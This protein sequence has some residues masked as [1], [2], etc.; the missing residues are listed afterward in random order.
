MDRRTGLG[1]RRYALPA[2]ALYKIIDMRKTILT[3]F[4]FLVVN[5]LLIWIHIT[6]FQSTF[7]WFG[8][9][10]GFFHIILLIIFPYKKIIKQNEIKKSDAAR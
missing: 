10:S 3:I 7:V 1:C 4:L 8:W 2:S 5:L 6:L 9:I